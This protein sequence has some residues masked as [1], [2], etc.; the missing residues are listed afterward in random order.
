V[1]LPE[2]PPNR[3]HLTFE[4]GHLCPV[5]S[6]VPELDVCQPTVGSYHG[7]AVRIF[8]GVIVHI[9]PESIEQVTHPPL[10]RES[11]AD[12]MLVVRCYP[13]LPVN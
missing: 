9:Q 11:Q 4:T 1:H 8:S 3:K 2:S 13:N 12:G 10:E 5:A 7:I 6:P